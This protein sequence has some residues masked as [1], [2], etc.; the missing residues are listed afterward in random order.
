VVHIGHRPT[1]VGTFKL[2]ISRMFFI[3]WRIAFNGRT[4]ARRLATMDT[5]W[6][7]LAMAALGAVSLYLGY[8]LFC[9][10]S[11][12]NRRVSNLVAGA[13]LAVFGLGLLFAQARGIAATAKH[14]SQRWTESKPAEQGS[15]TAPT[16]HRVHWVERSI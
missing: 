9:D 16:L 5:I 4:N 3:G 15:W 10:L 6:M 7:R 8:K 14:P 12:E 13:L 2:L 11:Q 1:G